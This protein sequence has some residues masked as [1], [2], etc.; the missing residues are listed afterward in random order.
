MK[1]VSIG[2]MIRALADLIGSGELS[3]IDQSFVRSAAEQS[4][5]GADTSK[6]SDKQVEIIDSVYRKHFS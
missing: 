4:G 2:S 5:Q 3:T 6:L 1:Q